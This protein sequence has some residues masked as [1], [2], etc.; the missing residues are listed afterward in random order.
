TNECRV[1]RDRER[2]DFQRTLNEITKS[3]SVAEA[4]QAKQIQA[5]EKRVRSCED[6]AVRSEKA[7]AE[8]KTRLSEAEARAARERDEQKSLLEVR[9]AETSTLEKEKAACLVERAACATERATCATERDACRAQKFSG[10]GKSASSGGATAEDA[11]AVKATPQ[12]TSP[13]P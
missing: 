2:N 4:E 1:S 9:S 12:E 3:G 6:T 7:C 8:E 10:A 11:P 5:Y 13:G